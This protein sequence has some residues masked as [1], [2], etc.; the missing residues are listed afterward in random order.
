MSENTLNVAEVLI[1]LG[2]VSGKL[3]SVSQTQTLHMAQSVAFQEKMD[4]RHEKL[5]DRVGKVENMQ[6]KSKGIFAGLAMA[7]TAVSTIIGFIAAWW[8]KGTPVG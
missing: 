8:T 3:D 2:E 4:I 7:G 5:E 6:A 1:K